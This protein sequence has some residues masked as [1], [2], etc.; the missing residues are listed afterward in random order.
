[1]KKLLL[2]L[3]AFCLSALPLCAQEASYERDFQVGFVSPLGTNGTNSSQTTN[4]VSINIL[5]GYSK[6][7]TIAEFAS[8]YNINTDYTKGGQF[9][10]VVNYSGELR[11]G[12]QFA[13]VANI[14]NN[15]EG[16]QF[17]GV[18]NTAKD[19]EGIQ[20]A[21]VL[22]I[23]KELEGVQLGLI[24]ICESCEE[25]VPI[26][27]INIVKEGGKCEFE[28]GI[29]ETLDNFVSFKLGTDRFY[30]IFSGGVNYI[31]T[32]VNYAVGM[33]FGTHMDWKKEGWANQ[34]E[35]MFYNTTEEGEF[36]KG[37]N[38]LTQLKFIVSKEFSQHF[39][40][41]AGP[42][43]NMTI[44]DYVNPETKEVGSSLVPWSMWT[45]DGD[46]TKLNGWVGLSAGIRF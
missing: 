18:I 3:S 46:K 30:T 13:G 21:T 39:K 9:A 34:I 41:F 44:S 23:A 17:A 16:G 20:V 25:G 1:M 33:G 11:N 38:M 5:G 35:A 14:S 10:G 24:N 4:K 26:G 27:L 31:N 42:V 36:R 12:A 28:I 45:N 32:P 43:L 40:V 15:V 6:A 29:S 37:K 7:N 19:V 22:N 2:S 8:I